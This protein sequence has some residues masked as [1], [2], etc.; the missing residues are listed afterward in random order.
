MHGAYI[1]LVQPVPIQLFSSDNNIF[2]LLI[3]SLS[4]ANFLSDNGKLFH[5]QAALNFTSCLPNEVL[6]YTGLFIS[7]VILVHL[8]IKKQSNYFG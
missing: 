1:S 2:N 4:D 7:N 6:Q 5:K 3:N 8:I